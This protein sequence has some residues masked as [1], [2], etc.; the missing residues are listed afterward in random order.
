M[1]V[2]LILVIDGIIIEN[3]IGKARVLGRKF[4]RKRK[5]E[6]MQS[7]KQ[8]LNKLLLVIFSTHKMRFISKMDY[9]QCIAMKIKV[10]FID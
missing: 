6:E 4:G 7:S 3:S 2:L 8:G 5:V 1:N 10:V 9:F